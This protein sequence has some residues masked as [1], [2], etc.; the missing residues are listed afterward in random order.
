M[1]VET[2]ANEDL[3]GTRMKTGPLKSA[4]I[5][6]LAIAGTGCSQSLAVRQKQATELAS[7]AQFELRLIQAGGFQLTTY[8]R[9]INQRTRRLSVYIEGDG[10]AYERKYRLSEN[11]TP[12]NPLGLKLAVKDPAESVLYLARPCMY[13]D[14]RQIQGCDAK[15][16]SSHRYAEEVVS[17]LDQVINKVTG[18]RSDLSIKL[19]GY[20][21]GGT[22]AALLAARRRDVN[23]LITVAANLD[24]QTW[25]QLHRISPLT[26]S[27]NPVDYAERLSALEQHHLLG[28]DDRIVPRGVIDSYLEKLGQ[29]SRPGIQLIPDFD[30]DCCWEKAWPELLDRF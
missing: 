11:P 7:Q 30:H 10:N 21:G 1:P 14:A 18:N 23:S 19:I 9:G 25:T 16:W 8:Q 22:V 15:Y 13:L 27:L 26:G 29:E 17:A 6:I 5:L 28:E 4:I 2:W 3:T 20:S 24:H 12:K